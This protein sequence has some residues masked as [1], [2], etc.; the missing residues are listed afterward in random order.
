MEEGIRILTYHRISYRKHPYLSVSPRQFYRQMDYLFHNGYRVI[1]LD[2]FYRYKQNGKMSFAKTV[3]ITFDDGYL[4]NYNNALPILKRHGFTATVFLATG[5]IG[6]EYLGEKM[7]DWAKIR[8]MGKNGVNFGSHSASHPFLTKVTREKAEKEIKDSKTTIE[9]VI[10]K[11]ITFFSYPAGDFNEAVQHIVQKCGYLG[12]CT[13]I[14][15]GNNFYGELFALK[16]TEIGP[17]DTFF[18]FK[19]KLVGAYDPIYKCLR[20]LKR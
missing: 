11:K 17:K 14:S 12:A 5:F 18:D 8:E 15:G 13:T 19:K 16:R 20:H 3:I 10:N 1:S 9:E 7:L 6:K 4:D 2:D